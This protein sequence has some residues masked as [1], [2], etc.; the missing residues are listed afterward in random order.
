MAFRRK[1]NGRTA[2]EKLAQDEATL[3]ELGYKQN[4]TRSWS[5]VNNFGISFSIISVITGITTLFEYG[6]VTGGPA[7]MSNGWIVVSVFSM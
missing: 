4:L 2:A 6:L 7:V 1:S 5:M 3:A